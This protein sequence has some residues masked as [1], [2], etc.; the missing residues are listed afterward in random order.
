MG[1]TISFD[2]G[3]VKR[4]LL[5]QLLTLF[6]SSAVSSIIS[7]HS[8]TRSQEAATAWSGQ[9]SNGRLTVGQPNRMPL[10]SFSFPLCVRGVLRPRAGPAAELYFS[11]SLPLREPGRRP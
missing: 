6:G 4:Q 5:R 9:D 11:L 8:K 1:A 10:S 7:C 2:S 3:N